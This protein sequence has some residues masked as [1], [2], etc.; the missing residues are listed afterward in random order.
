MGTTKHREAV[1]VVY[2]PNMLTFGELLQTYRTQIDPT[3]A[4]GQFADRGYQY[5]TAIYYSNETEK[6]QAETSKQVLAQ[7]L[8]KTIA[9]QILPFDTFYPA[10]DYHQNYYKTNSEH[11]KSY[12]K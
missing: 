11:Y 12:K 4:G 2:N 5:T 10:E 8:G 6:M 7:K 3:D 1:K 9:V